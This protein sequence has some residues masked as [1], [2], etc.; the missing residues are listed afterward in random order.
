MKKMLH[1]VGYEI[2]AKRL[3]P[4][5]FG[6]PQIRDRLYVVGSRNGLDGFSW[7]MQDGKGK[8]SI[9]SALEDNPNDARGLSPQALECLEVWQAFL[10]KF[11]KNE[12]LPSFPIWSMEFGATYPF[13]KKTPYAV[14]HQTLHRY[15][16]SHGL[17]LGSLSPEVRWLCVPSYART[18]EKRF[19]DWKIDFI[20]QNREL[21]AKHKKWIDNWL[22][23]IL[24][25]PP[26]LQKLEWNCKG[27]KRNIWRHVIQFR[28]SG[29][30]I[31]RL[32]TSPSLVAMTTTQVPI[33]GWQK[34][35]M[36][37]RECANL[38]SFKELKF[39]P[40]SST[41]AYKTLGNAVNSDVVELIAKSLIK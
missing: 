4:H 11:P 28:A 14:K 41:S 12:E 40:M 23:S 21:Y 15:R 16:G 2:E 17:P 18:E 7:P 38:Q 25:F 19:P 3:S 24:Q 39:L 1:R 8:T 22:P 29:V 6:V 34:R 35:Y 5:Q 13:R 37:P 27:D 31:K 30:R 9:L 10:E 33:I 26:S 32:A 20:S 36:T